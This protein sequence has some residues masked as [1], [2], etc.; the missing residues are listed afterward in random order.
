MKP[1]L[2]DRQGVPVNIGKEIAR[3]GEGAI[4]EIKGH[5][6]FV[7]KVY[8]KPVSEAKAA[9]LNAMVD[10]KTERLIQLAAW[11]V[12]VIQNTKKEVVGVVLPKIQGYKD[13]HLLYGPRSRM[14]EFPQATWPFLVRTASNLARAFSAIHDAGHVIGD[15]NDKVALVSE[16]SIV[17]LIDCDGFQVQAN[18][19]LY[20]CDVGVLTH[21]PPEHQNVKTF[22]GL[23]RTTNHDNFGLAVLVFQL[24]FMARHPFSGS[25]EGPEDMSI[26]RAIKEYRYVYG[27]DAAKKKMKAP[28]YAIG[29]AMLPAEVSDLFE[30]AFDEGSEKKARPTPKEW[31]VALENLFKA[32]Q[33]CKTNPSHAFVKE[34]G[35][36]PFC[37]LESKTG[38][39]LFNLPVLF[40][41]KDGHKRT[42]LINIGTI[43]KDIRA[44][45]APGVLAPFEKLAEGKD[46]H[47]KP[48]KSKFIYGASGLAILGGA[49]GLAPI[50]GNASLTLL[51]GIPPLWLLFR[52]EGSR[53]GGAAK[54]VN[55]I[56]LRWKAL[57]S[58]REFQKY[59]AKLVE[60]KKALDNLGKEHERRIREVHSHKER[61]QLEVWLAKHKIAPGK[62][63]GISSAAVAILQSYGIESAKDLKRKALSEVPTIG[64]SRVKSLL[65][66][67]QRLEKSF[68]FD[69]GQGADP[70]AIAEVERAIERKRAELV[71]MLSEGPTKLEQIA[72]QTH[73]RR[74]ALKTEFDAV[75]ARMAG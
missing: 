73:L 46:L 72:R 65:A 61:G 28:P 55:E 18:K 32:A 6:K 2:F 33:R 4:L 39:A 38:S 27:R 59:R 48:P 74:A 71:Q 41:T 9:K 5:P 51:G 22:R 13:V 11:P 56:Q 24:L 17:R 67:R 36:C 35:H 16:K 58:P 30:R 54:K 8:H 19:K 64:P 7:A 40:Q 44:V 47:V 57:S 66:W 37:E 70:N 14:K 60:A 52:G 12:E 29:P 43:W 26:E 75:C 15:V 23:R 34:K 63:K 10:T 20:P 50:T 62:I 31:V 53:K 3:G 21:Q 42:A 45:K 25:Y 49:I 1:E 69:A 68:A